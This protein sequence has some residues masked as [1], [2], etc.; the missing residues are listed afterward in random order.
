VRKR[1]LWIAAI[2]AATLATVYAS[3]ILHR[4]QTAAK[5][6]A[7]AQAAATKTQF[8]AR[9]LA[10][11]PTAV[12]WTSFPAVFT[13]FAIFQNRIYITTPA[14]LLEYSPE[15]AL[16]HRWPAGQELPPAPLGALAVAATA[17]GAGPALHIAT[18][19]GGLVVF[20]G[21]AF[22]QILPEDKRHRRIAAMLPIDAGRLLLGTAAGVLSFDGRGLQ[23]LHKSLQDLN[24]TALAGDSANLWIGAEGRGLYHWQAGALATLTEKDGLPDA[25]VSAIAV[26]SDAAYAATPMG[27]AEIRGGRVRRVLAPGF[28]ASALLAN[29]TTLLAGSFDQGIA[30]IALESRPRQTR[31]QAEGPEGAVRKLLPWDGRI[32]ALTA[33]GLYAAS[34]PGGRWDTLIR[35]DPSTLTDANLSALAVDRA[36]RLWAGYFDRGLDVVEDGRVRHFENDSLFCVNRIVPSPDGETVAIATANGL[37]IFD[38]AGR[39]RNVL[40]RLQGLIADHVTDV[41]FRDG[42]MI[43][44]TPSGITFIDAAGT[45]SVSDFHGLV[46]QHVYALAAA[47]GEVAAGTLGGLSLLR[48]GI[49]RASFT[50]ANSRL[51]HNWITAIARADGSWFAGTYGAGVARFENGE[52]SAFPDLRGSIVINP[53]A[54]LVTPER[55]YAGS[56]ES[57]LLIFDRR[58]RRWHATT[59]GL[60]SVNVTAL[61]AAGGEL[62][63]GTDNGLVRLNERSLP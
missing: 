46:N 62:Y 17:G 63:A 54:M 47:D 24:V 52:W 44:A 25:H 14:A 56:M 22:T 59:E 27:I 61:A 15:G 40:R 6:A 20:D 4:A 9:R 23:P 36:G 13:D 19:G 53:N 45:Q 10:P 33:S 26:T 43:L 39:Q 2:S 12:S 57:G 29:G 28:F 49:V 48:Q 58:T 35:P 5:E 32:L 41:V 16:Q 55:V 51:Q 8:T 60:P 38:A 34:T 37:V 30:A 21:S 31:P 3:V 7:T 18:T 50:T 1:K 11:T 42:A